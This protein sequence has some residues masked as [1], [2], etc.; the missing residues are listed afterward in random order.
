MGT[1]HSA[2]NVA[3]AAALALC[4]GL[5]P[6][7]RAAGAAEAANAT[8]GDSEAVV[9]LGAIRA[10]G[11]AMPIDQR[12]DLD[13]RIRAMIDRAN[14]DASKR[15]QTVVAK[16]LA[17][18]FHTSID[19]LFEEKGTLG[20]SWGEVVM[21][22]TLLENAAVKVTPQDLASLREGG[23]G[24]AAIAYGLKFHLEDLEDVIKAGGKIASGLSNSETAPEAR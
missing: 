22:H 12:I 13:K 5:T 10:R 18:E 21:A 17:A 7:A 16:K 9:D 15:G 24:W 19:A 11:A 23:L 6:H 2:R 1:S 3:V 4:L 20:W 8:A 14:D